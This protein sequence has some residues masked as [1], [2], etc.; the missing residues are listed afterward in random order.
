[1]DG[2]GITCFAEKKLI[3]VGQLSRRHWHGRQ[4]SGT[5]DEGSNLSVTEIAIQSGFSD[6][7]HFGRLFRK[8]YGVTSKAFLKADGW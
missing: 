8:I 4:G 1:M 3:W 7:S 5:Q 2:K 6:Q